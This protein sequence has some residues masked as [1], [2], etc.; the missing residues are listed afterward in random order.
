VQVVHPRQAIDDRLRELKPSA[1]FS[2]WSDKDAAEM[3]QSPRKPPL[4]VALLLPV[5]QYR[6]PPDALRATQVR[7]RHCAN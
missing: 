5:S 4:P 6:T 2:D 3:L 7:R 1:D